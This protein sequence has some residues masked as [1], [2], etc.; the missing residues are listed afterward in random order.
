MLYVRE[1][2]PANILATG[3]APLESV[4]IELILWNTKWLLHCSYNSH[5]NMIEQCLTALSEYLDLYSSNYEKI[6]I[7]GDFNVSVKENHMKCFCDIYGLETLI[8]KPTCYKN[9]ENPTCIEL[10]LTNKCTAQ[11]SKH[12][13]D[14]NRFVWLSFW[15]LWLLSEKNI[16]NFSQE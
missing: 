12:M 2:I 11:F 1:G 5:K 15:C 14:R 13:C 8:K 4:C 6:L 7:L 9:S 16:K 10:M 3:N